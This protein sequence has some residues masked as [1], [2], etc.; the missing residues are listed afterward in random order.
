MTEKPYKINTG[1]HIPSS[2]VIGRDEVIEFLWEKL[3]SQSIRLTA[4]RRIGKTSVIKKMRDESKDGWIVVYR[5]VSHCNTPQEFVQAT[6]NL[7]YEYFTKT[8]KYSENAKTFFNR[9]SKVNLGKAG[10]E[11]DKNEKHNWKQHFESSISKIL[12]DIKDHKLLLLYDEVPTMLTKIMDTSDHQDTISI[13]DM[14]RKIRQENGEQIRMIYT[15]S[16]GIHHVIN[17]LKKKKYKDEPL[18]DMYFYQLKPLDEKNAK[19][20]AKKIIEGENL[21]YEPDLDTVTSIVTSITNRFPFYI[22]HVFDKLKSSGKTVSRESIIE[23]IIDQLT[24][25]ND[26][27]EMEHF[28]SRLSVYGDGLS[29]VADRTLTLLATEGEK[30]IEDLLS[31]LVQSDGI[32]IEKKELNKL[33]KSLGQDHYLEKTKEKK[34]KWTSEIVRRWWVLDEGYDSEEA[35]FDHG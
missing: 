34:W 8:S 6:Y 15:G 25:I 10:V 19:D 16:V 22:Q 14:L 35:G 5:D 26:P 4:E 3:E 33:L 32:S 17:E 11:L 1:G 29:E 2:K 23:S 13:L 21:A 18:N 28:R 7:I 24:S 12:E 20:L 30:T 27:W 9:V 31:L